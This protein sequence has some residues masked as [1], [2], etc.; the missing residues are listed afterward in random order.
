MDVKG[1][2]DCFLQTQ[3]IPSKYFQHM[4]HDQQKTKQDK[5]ICLFRI[6]QK[7]SKIEYELLYILVNKYPYIRFYK[8][9]TSTR[10]KLRTIV[11]KP[12]FSTAWMDGDERE[13]TVSR[14]WMYVMYD[15]TCQDEIRN[16]K[17]STSCAKIQNSRND[18]VAW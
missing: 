16:V 6:F 18:S 12:R 9:C 7:K 15:C 10:E 14:Q 11:A 17:S 8:E 4:T 13:G 1:Y 5:W 3:R 2:G